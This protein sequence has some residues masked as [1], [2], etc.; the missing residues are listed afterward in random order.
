[1]SENG[2]AQQ[3]KGTIG[4]KSIRKTCLAALAAAC[5]LFALAGCSDAGTTSSAPADSSSSSASASSQKPEKDPAGNAIT[6]PDE[7]NTILSMAPSITQTLC[8]LGL[9]DK[10]VAMDTQSKAYAE[11]VKEGIPEFDMMQPDTEQMISL[12]PDLVLVSGISDVSGDDP[13]KALKDVGI[14]VANIP[15]SSSIEG[16]KSDVQFIADCVGKSDEGKALVDGMQED[17]DAIR[18][19]GETITDKKTVLF[20]IAAAPQIYSFGKNTFLDEMITL[21]GA[22]NVL[23]DQDSWISVTEE[24]AVSANP[25]V[26]LTNVNYLTVDPVEEIKGR[27]GWEEVTA[28]KNGAVYYIDNGASSLPNHHI[29]DALKQMAKAVYPEQYAEIDDPFAE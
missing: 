10:I 3:E 9:A 28:V 13:F 12:K 18:A 8:D 26:I 25:D 11:G 21:I 20:E 23:G 19:I 15:S 6:V 24:A 5:M 22:T 29:V 2:D 16:V 7:V 27:S 14:C 1:M 17:I 4:M